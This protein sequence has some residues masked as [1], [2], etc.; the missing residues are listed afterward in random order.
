[1]GKE[2]ENHHQLLCANADL[3]RAAALGEVGEVVVA[4]ED[5]GVVVAGKIIELV[6][7]RSRNTTRSS[8]DT[9]TTF[10]DYQRTK[11]MTSGQ[12]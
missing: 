1:M 9:T 3:H 11:R 6:S 5:A 4:F 12:H 8:K 10:W 2:Y 7:T